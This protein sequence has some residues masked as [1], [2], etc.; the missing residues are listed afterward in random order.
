MTSKDKMR[1][2]HTDWVTHFVRD[3]LPDQDF[4]G[5]DA[6]ESGYYHGGELEPNAEAFSVLK[7][8]IRL[9][10]ITPGY[11]F[12]GGRTTIYGGQPAVCATE[13]PLYSFAQYARNRGDSAKV[14]AYGIS[15]L[16]SEFYQAGGR[17]VIYGLSIDKPPFVENTSTR[18]IFHES[19]LPVA[20]QY[21]FVAYNP[22]GSSKWV[23]W[24]HEREWRWVPQ[25]EEQD[26]IWAQ[27]YDGTF[28]STP[29]LP[30]FKGRLEGR[31]FS[32]VC[33]IVWTKEEANEIR[34]ML[35]G[36]YLAGS[37]NYD[38]PFDKKLIAASRIIVLQD[39]VDLVEGGKDLE[40]QTIE[41]LQAA[42]LLAPIAL[43]D[44]PANAV[45]LVKDAMEKAG[46]A[47][48][49]AALAYFQKYGDNGYCGYANAVTYE[50]T[51]PIVQYMLKE[52]LASGPFDGRVHINFP[53][54]Y[55][56]CQT[57]DYDEAACEAAAQ[58]LSAELGVS[59]HCES[60][61]D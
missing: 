6:E 1:H 37:N 11:S 9:G 49:A 17:P 42:N 4:P 35:T 41:G 51:S 56:A 15:F 61:G 60:R 20:E 26:E 5:D 59:V 34:E 39:A 12:R 50:V 29:A 7:A 58:V 57:L 52:G 48:K 8:I 47:A 32:R 2:D 36:F 43:P 27:G 10:G 24:S 3:R 22:S 19:V 53:K 40:A 31:P 55:P 13:M 28:D 46:A 21:R 25:D 44:P 54:D 38:T 45:V 33:I 30:L 16:K 23:D 18:R 14:S